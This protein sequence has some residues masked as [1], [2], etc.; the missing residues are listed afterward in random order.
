MIVPVVGHETFK[1][2]KV[3]DAIDL[4]IK[5]GKREDLK[6]SNPLAFLSN[7]SDKERNLAPIEELQPLF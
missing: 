5:T 6:L 3:N 7:V 1:D 4:A 2:L